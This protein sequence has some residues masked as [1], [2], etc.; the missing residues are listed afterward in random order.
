M[1]GANQKLNSFFLHRESSWWFIR[2]IRALF[3][4]I[5]L[6]RVTFT[7]WVVEQMRWS[8]WLGLSKHIHSALVTLKRALKVRLSSEI[9][10]ALFCLEESRCVRLCCLWTVRLSFQVQVLVRSAK[11]V[12]YDDDSRAVF[13]KL[14]KSQTLTTSSWCFSIKCTNSKA[15][16][17]EMFCLCFQVD[18][19]LWFFHQYKLGATV[20]SMEP[21]WKR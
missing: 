4:C 9:K 6:C 14:S 13:G 20:N 11:M 8:G 7:S 5:F 3:A 12:K 15:L 1:T 10:T 19:N 17:L 21:L 16:N 2:V 18:F